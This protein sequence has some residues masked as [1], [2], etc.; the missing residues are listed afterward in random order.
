MTKAEAKELAIDI[1]KHLQDANCGDSTINDIEEYSLLDTY[2]NGDNR[3]IKFDDDNPTFIG[4]YDSNNY[5]TFD[6]G[7]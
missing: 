5:P 3:T 6:C 4:A 2:F 1:I 7:D